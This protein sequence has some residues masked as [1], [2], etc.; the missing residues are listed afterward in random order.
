MMNTVFN[1]YVAVLGAT[2]TAQRTDESGVTYLFDLLLGDP[3]IG[4]LVHPV[5]LVN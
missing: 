2:T 3:A 1:A 5:S 4:V